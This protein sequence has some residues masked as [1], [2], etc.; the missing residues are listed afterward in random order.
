MNL[1]KK[2]KPT[3]KRIRSVKESFGDKPTT[4]YV[5]TNKEFIKNNPDK[6]IKEIKPELR[7]YGNSNEFIK[8]VFVGYSY[9]GKE[10]FVVQADS[11]NVHNFY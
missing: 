1:F 10:L 3:D 8:S 6:A 5:S 11:V 2:S 9:E 4:Y 7:Q